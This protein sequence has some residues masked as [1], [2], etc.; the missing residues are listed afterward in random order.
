MTPEQLDD[1]LVSFGE[2]VSMRSKS[3]GKMIPVAKLREYISKAIE[4][5]EHR[6]K[7]PKKVIPDVNKWIHVEEDLPKNDTS[8]LVYNKEWVDGEGVDGGWWSKELNGWYDS[9]GYE[10]G[11][12]SGITHWQPMPEP[13]SE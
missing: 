1:Y 6:I 9:Y 4:T 2:N 13:P 5:A 8:V 11:E 7:N 3:G 12:M 10:D